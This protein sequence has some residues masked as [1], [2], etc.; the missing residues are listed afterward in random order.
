MDALAVAL[1]LVR[2]QRLGG[3]VYTSQASR[4]EA[5]HATDKEN[6]QYDGDKK[7]TTDRVAHMEAEV[8][9]TGGQ[10]HSSVPTAV[11]NSSSG[12]SSSRNSS[13]KVPSSKQQH[14]STT[15][16]LNELVEALAEV[17]AATEKDKQL[18]QQQDRS[19]EP[20]FL[21][22]SALGH[23]VLHTVRNITSST[24]NCTTVRMKTPV[25]SH[26]SSTDDVEMPTISKIH[27]EN[28]NNYS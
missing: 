12:R 20:V 17:A 1:L 23:K 10:Q 2:D 27:E 8:E 7:V 6:G 4:S 13:S 15:T 19:A 22:W 18:M 21:D 3:K 9:Q 26:I 28:N 16:L 5:E 24:S 11:D 25:N 14:I